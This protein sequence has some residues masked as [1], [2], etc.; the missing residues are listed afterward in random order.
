[1]KLDILHVEGDCSNVLYKGNVREGRLL[2]SEGSYWQ[3]YLAVKSSLQIL[4][5]LELVISRKKS[6]L[7]EGCSMW[8]YEKSWSKLGLE[9]GE[10]KHRG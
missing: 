6:Q 4:V 2:T 1:M 5:Y 9:P 8:C 10:E 3:A 7:P